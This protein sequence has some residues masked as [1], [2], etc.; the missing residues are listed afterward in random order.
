[1]RHHTRVAPL[2]DSALSTESSVVAESR[3]GV[4]YDRCREV[5]TSKAQWDLHSALGFCASVCSRV[6]DLG[7]LLAFLGVFNE[8]RGILQS[9]SADA[10]FNL[11]TSSRLVV[12]PDTSADS[13]VTRGAWDA[14]LG[15][16]RSM[17]FT[18]V[19]MCLSR[20]L[21]RKGRSTVDCKTGISESGAIFRLIPFSGPIRSGSRGLRNRPEEASVKIN[22]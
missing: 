9:S 15:L 8:T 10:S 21:V 19:F 13:V 11:A 7:N 16:Y 2:F 18:G 22:C 12:K 14:G 5:K 20:L 17:S 3:I 1:M 4:A 6:G